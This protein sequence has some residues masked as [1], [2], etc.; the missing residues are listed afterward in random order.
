VQHVATTRH[1]DI[2][3]DRTF[4]FVKKNVS[5]AVRKDKKKKK[6]REKFPQMHQNLGKIARWKD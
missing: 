6:G 4:L 1:H 3:G 5:Q 2:R